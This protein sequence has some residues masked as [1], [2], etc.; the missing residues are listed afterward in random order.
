MIV[1][2]KSVADKEV[3]S[4]N[5]FTTGWRISQNIDSLLFAG[6][7]ADSVKSDV[8]GQLRLRYDRSKPYEE[9]IPYYR[10]HEKVRDTKL[11]D[12]YVV[13]AGWDDI[14][15][16]LDANRIAYRVIQ[17]DTVIKVQSTVI[18]DY[19]TVSRPYEGHYVHYETKTRPRNE[20]INFGKGSLL[21]KTDQPGNRYLAQVF[22]PEN[23]DSFFAWNF[24]DSYLTQKEYFSDYI[25]EETAAEL[26]K[27]NSQLRKAFEEKR[28]SV[29]A[30]AANAQA[31]LD[32]IYQ[33][34]VHK[35]AVHLRMPVFEILK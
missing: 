31:Q 11:P 34:S 20:T 29:A 21:I 23:E 19:K 14:K 32:F 16:R 5:T 8:T 10:Y 6:Y 24:F 2:M 30:F 26:L 3:T 7:R 12:Y 18:E 35:E 27:R 4:A 13:S 1:K 15:S 22:N 28:A 9:K 17:N 33:N 25:F